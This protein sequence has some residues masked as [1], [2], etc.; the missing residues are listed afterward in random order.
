MLFEQC[1]P[2]KT[3]A[4]YA[5]FARRLLEAALCTSIRKVGFEQCVHGSAWDRDCCYCDN[6]MEFL[7]R[8]RPMQ[9]YFLAEGVAEFCCGAAKAFT[10]KYAKSLP[11]CPP[12]AAPVGTTFLTQFVRPVT[13]GK[14]LGGFALHFPAGERRSSVV[15]VPRVRIPVSQVAEMHFYFCASDGEDTVLANEDSPE[16]PI[17]GEGSWIAKLV[18]GLSLYLDA[19][20]GRVVAAS[21]EQVGKIDAYAGV[22]HFV[23]RDAGAAPGGGRAPGGSNHG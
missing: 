6:L 18:F 9:H 13:E 20:P 5:G 2:A 21:D 22:R 7:W 3:E 4:E 19:F 8:Y 17:F 16:V 10:K 23:G 14:M 1:F 15:V 11:V 12:V